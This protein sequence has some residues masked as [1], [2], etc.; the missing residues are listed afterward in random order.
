MSWS[1]TGLRRGE[2]AV[3]IPGSRGDTLALTRPSAIAVGLRIL[4]PGYPQWA[5]RQRGRGLVLFGSYVAALAVGFFCWGTP[6]G[7]VLLTFAYGTHVA[8]VTDVIRQQAFPGFGRWVPM[9]SAGGGLGLGFY[10]PAMVLASLIAW[11]GMGDGPAP[12]GYLVDCRAY[13]TVAPRHGDWVWFRSP[14][15]GKERL[16]RVVAGPGQEVEWSDGQFQLD[17]QRRPTRGFWPSPP[18]RDDVVLTVPA[19]HVLV[20]PG[21][22]RSS[23]SAAES[24]I[25][26][27]RSDVLGR[28]WARFY[29]IRERQFLR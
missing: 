12:D 8:S 29:P 14:L 10:G 28:A 18:H 24:P 3:S 23:R 11:S 1:G 4:V 7:F 25:L 21:V 6:V 15:G 27:R 19:D 9:V 5:W 26:V 13:A 22:P 16:G 2:P 17:G 20:V